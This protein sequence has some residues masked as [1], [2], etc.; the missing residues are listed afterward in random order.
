MS[1]IHAEIT[2]DPDGNVFLTDVGSTH[3]TFIDG[4]RI[5]PSDPQPVGPDTKVKFGKSSRTYR[6]GKPQQSGHAGPQKAAAGFVS[7]GDRHS[8]GRLEEL[9]KALKFMLRPSAE[10]RSYD[11]RPDGYVAVASLIESTAFTNYQYTEEEIVAMA[12]TVAAHLYELAQLPGG[13]Y[14]RLRMEGGTVVG[15]LVEMAIEMEDLPVLYHA[16]MFTSFN[17][18]RSKGLEAKLRSPVI[19]LDHL[20]QKGE[21]CP[22]CNGAPQI[23]VEMDVARMLEKG[24]KLYVDGNENVVCAGN[25]QGWIPI[26]FFSACRNPKNREEMLSMEDIQRVQKQEAE[27]EAKSREDQRKADEAKE[28]GLVQ[29]ASV[30]YKMTGETAVILKV[31]IEDMPPYYTVS[32]GSGREKQT[33]AERLEVISAE[34]MAAAKAASPKKKKAEEAPPPPVD[35]FGLDAMAGPARKKKRINL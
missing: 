15:P 30:R 35:Y 8:R 4:E 31:H 29:G 12:S 19:F 24:L 9:A 20:P 2:V 27:E 21:K 25:A 33:T 10:K 26:S 13:L 11:M 32:F 28:R 23:L 14:V 16:T 7:Q 5:S 6:L 18:V 1:R 22:G 34:E 17:Q 3:G